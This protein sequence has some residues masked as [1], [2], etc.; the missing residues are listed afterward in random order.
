M[1]NAKTNRHAD[2]AQRKRQEL[3]QQLGGACVKCGKTNKLEID[4]KN[5]R[6]YKLEKLS[7]AGR[8]RRYLKEALE[9]LLQVLCPPCN[10]AKGGRT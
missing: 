6:D 10:K 8:V 5:G 1:G 9:G 4:H 7:Q 3:I 2:W